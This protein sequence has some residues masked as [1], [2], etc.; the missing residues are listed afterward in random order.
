MHN[1]FCD[2]AKV[3]MKGGTQD[4]AKQEAFKSAAKYLDEQEQYV[5]QFDT[6]MKQMSPEQ[7][8]IV[9]DALGYFNILLV[10]GPRKVEVKGN[11]T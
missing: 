1:L 7:R 4:E 11:V 5:R 8:N 2:I 3:V 10:T 6:Q 9:M